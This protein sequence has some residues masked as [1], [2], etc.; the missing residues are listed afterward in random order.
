MKKILFASLVLISASSFA[1]SKHSAS[2]Q[3]V[4]KADPT[5]GVPKAVLESFNSR[6]ASSS[7]VTWSMRATPVMVIYVADFYVYSG[8]AGAKHMQA[9]Y[10]ADG[11]FLGKHVV[12]PSTTF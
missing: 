1:S 9:A 10:T 4:R 8:T 7:N 6:F 5:D 11:K 2:S 12:E 3:V